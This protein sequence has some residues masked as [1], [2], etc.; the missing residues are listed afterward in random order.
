MEEVKTDEPGPKE[1]S[2]IRIGSVEV[3]QLQL[4]FK[5]FFVLRIKKFLKDLGG[6]VPHTSGSLAC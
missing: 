1:D 4:R 2:I 5:K 6:V 3:E